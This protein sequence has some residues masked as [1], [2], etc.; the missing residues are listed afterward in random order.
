MPSAACALLSRASPGGLRTGLRTAEQPAAQRRQSQCAA[1]VQN[2]SE[3]PPQRGS[4]GR[5]SSAATCTLQEHPGT[6][7]GLWSGFWSPE[8]ERAAAQVAP[9]PGVAALQTQSVRY[10]G[11]RDAATPCGWLLSESTAARAL[12]CPTGRPLLPD[13]AAA[14][15]VPGSAGVMV[16]GLPRQVSMTIVSAPAEFSLPIKKN[17]TFK[18]SFHVQVRVTHH[19]GT[20]TRLPLRVKAFAVLRNRLRPGLASKWLPC[21]ATP[22]DTAPRGVLSAAQHAQHMTHPPCIGRCTCKKR[23]AVPLAGGATMSHCFLHTPMHE[24]TAPHQ[25]PTHHSV[26]AGAMPGWA[27]GPAAPT[28]H[29]CGPI[30]MS[31]AT[32]CQ[33]VNGAWAPRNLQSP[34]E[35]MHVV[36]PPCPSHFRPLPLKRMNSG[37]AA[38]G[39]V[40]SA[41]LKNP[42]S[43]VPRSTDP[44]LAESVE[45]CC[46]VAQ[47]SG[48]MVS[49]VSVARFDFETLRFEK[50]SRM[51]E[52]QMVFACII[53]GDLLYCAYH[54]PTVS[55]CRAEQRVPA[56]LTLHLPPTAHDDVLALA[57]RLRRVS[58]TGAASSMLCKEQHA[59]CARGVPG[60]AMLAHFQAVS[61][62]GGQ[63]AAAQQAQHAAGAR[64]DTARCGEERQL[65]QGHSSWHAATGGWGGAAHELVLMHT[66]EPPSPWSLWDVEDLTSLASVDFDRLFASADLLSPVGAM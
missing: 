45:Q 47:R 2:L 20:P 18:P 31:S 38:R 40:R 61:E 41:A 50:P 52:V 3:H 59:K 11:C 55:I 29:A 30:S 66:D 63:H 51:T 60:E 14:S 64:C 7:A 13:L 65:A 28:T 24:D 44:D 62:G 35:R 27:A 54:V 17:R 56:A 58:A 48:A 10:C 1:A 49:P 6:G 46:A 23:A 26:P 5:R 32:S 39:G 57:E 4:C 8:V 36:P 12:R 16:V 21:D 42:E 53:G 34:P 19:A 43:L 15:H 33:A 9:M 37:R 22:P 25:S